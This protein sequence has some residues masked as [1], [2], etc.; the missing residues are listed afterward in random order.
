MRGVELD[1]AGGAKVVSD[2]VNAYN[3]AVET[4]RSRIGTSSMRKL[5]SAVVAMAVAGGLA[6]SA[7]ARA[8]GPSRRSNHPRA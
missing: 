8:E 1:A 3:N 6:I 5:F 4:A 2:G 7:P